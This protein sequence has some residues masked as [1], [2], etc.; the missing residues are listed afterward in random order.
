MFKHIAAL[1]LTIVAVSGSSEPSR[2]LYDAIFD[3]YIPI[4]ETAGDAMLSKLFAQ[5]RE[6]IWLRASQVAAFQAMLDPMADL[7]VFQEKC[8]VGEIVRR[9]GVTSF[10]HLAGPDRKQLI[11]RLHS[12]D[13]IL[14][15]RNAMRI[16]NFFLIS[17][18]GPLQ[19]PLTGVKLN[20][21]ADEK[22][23][24]GHR[25][26]LPATRLRYDGEKHELRRDDGE[27]DYLI[28]GSGPAGSVLAHELRRGGK[29][30]LLLERGSYTVPGSMETRLID[31][32]KES[33]GTRTSADGAILIKNGLGVGGG[34]LV[35]VD[36]SFAPTLPSIQFKID[37]WRMAGRI[38][39]DDFQLGDLE[40]AYDWVKKAI[41]TRILSEGEIN[42]NNR[43]LWDGALRS[44]LHPKL[45]DLNTYP[46]GKSP[47]PVTDKRSA[48]TELIEKALLDANNPLSL[49]PDAEVRRVL[50][51][52]GGWNATGVE[53]TMRAPV[54]GT[55][56]VADPNGLGL[57]PG[58]TFHVRA[59]QVILSAGSLGSPAILLRS[60]V[61][62][63]QIGRGAVMHVSMPILGKFDHNVDVLSGTQASV[64]V[65]DRLMRQGYA[66]ESMSAEPLYGAIMAMGSP[67]FSFETIRAYR[68][69][70][71]FGVMLI[72]TPSPENRV[73]LGTDGEPE[74]EYQISE[75]D[76]QRF[77]QG[78]AEAVRIIFRAGA[79]EVFLPTN[80]DILSKNTKGELRVQ[81]LTNAAQAKLVGKNLKFIPNRSIV[82]SAH[83]QAT[84][85][86]GASATDSV[87]D[88]DFHVWGTANLFVVDGSIFPTSIGA[89]PMQSIY[90]FAKIFADQQLKR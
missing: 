37:Q 13:D 85:K 2:A 34:S 61:P 88:K 28:V 10:N 29:R 16:R 14:V 17:T 21:Y 50:F 6:G 1:S 8:G 24:E 32:L 72:D 83:M 58:E 22:Y 86:M 12:C 71:G 44:H 38:G 30:V 73:V 78:V 87:V 75:A 49:L 15:R 35:N 62:N 5:A 64:F 48:A 69:L 70:G 39:R 20:L 41:G 46:P 3:A 60:R 67:G 53:V 31:D 42:T 63:R 45:Y 47:Y 33:N 4:E 55:G 65:D 7:R 36:L 74:V 57:K 68:R 25:P 80:E 19:E 77:R 43:K 82:T 76:K 89:N 23:I 90:T 66:L 56:I 51:S 84:N 11:Y 26:N 9:T 81:V 18:Y 54:G 40:R 52:D 27:I 59:R 79:K